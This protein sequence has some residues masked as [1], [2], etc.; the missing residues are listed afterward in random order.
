MTPYEQGFMDKCAE[1]GVDPAAFV[2]QS[3]VRPARLILGEAWKRLPRDVR[4]KLGAELVKGLKGA[5]WLKTKGFGINPRIQRRTT[6][7][8]GDALY[9]GHHK[10]PILAH[11]YLH[12]TATVRK[13]ALQFLGWDS[14]SPAAREITGVTTFPVSLAR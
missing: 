10:V 5:G 3:A 7:A 9:P 4:K 8:F 1:L 12:G 14:I 6:I 11:E 13:P 2:K